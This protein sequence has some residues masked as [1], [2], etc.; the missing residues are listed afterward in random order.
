MNFISG[1]Q[2]NATIVTAFPINITGG[3]KS[4]TTIVGVDA[5]L[6]SNKQV[7]IY[8]SATALTATTINFKVST[9]S[10]VS[11]YLTSVIIGAYIFNYDELNNNNRVGRFNTGNFGSVGTASALTYTDS[12]GF[13][14]TTNTI[15]GTNTYHIVNQNYLHIKCVI[16]PNNVISATTNYSFSYMAFN[17]L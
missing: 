15:L 7:D 10:P 16:S 9:I 13:V 2:F 4:W 12:S 3:S 1:Q 6:A 17:Y 11:F 8:V 14:R 5:S